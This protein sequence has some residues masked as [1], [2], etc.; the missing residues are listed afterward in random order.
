VRVDWRRPDLDGVDELLGH[1][2]YYG[3]GRSEAAQC[4]GQS[5][6]VV[7][8]GNSAGKAVLNFANAAAR[9]TMLVRGDRLG[10]TMS[11]YLIERM[12]Q[13]PLM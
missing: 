11:A 8:A 13:H 3:A 1:G 6:V 9:V 4:A 10:M 12:K 7:G 5:V 2:V